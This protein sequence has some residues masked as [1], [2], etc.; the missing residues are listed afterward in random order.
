LG[1][2]KRLALMEFDVRSHA[3]PSNLAKL[4]PLSES[5]VV[6]TIGNQ[7]GPL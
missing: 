4:P 1:A 6:G 7:F 3:L 2:V 5:L